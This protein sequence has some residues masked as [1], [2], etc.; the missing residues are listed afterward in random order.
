MDE[1]IAKILNKL[2]QG[3]RDAHADIVALRFLLVT[4][5]IVT[6]SELNHWLKRARALSLR[7]AKGEEAPEEDLLELLQN[8]EGP[9]Q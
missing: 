9:E 4:N 3:L 8:F 6:E 7:H 2:A 5:K 1:E